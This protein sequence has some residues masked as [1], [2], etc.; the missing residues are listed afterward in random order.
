MKQSTNKKW[1]TLVELIVVITILA[2]LWT[3]AFISLQWYSS[4]ARDSKRISD[5][6]NIKKSLELFSLSTW[7]Y[8]LP[9]NW[10][11]ATF[12]WKTIWTQWTVWD[13]V[14]INLSKNL[15]KKPLDPLTELE[16]T[17]SVTI[18]KNE[19]ELLAIY[20]NIDTFS[21]N[22]I[23]NK[24][25][26]SEQIYPKIDG[27]YNWIVVKTPE[28]IIPTPSI[29][30]GEI[31][32]SNLELDDTNIN[33]QI[34]TWIYE[35]WVLDI[36]FNPVES[37]DSNSSE[38]E[39]LLVIDA[40]QD[41]YS[42]T[43]LESEPLY[44]EL[45]STN[46]A[47]EEIELAEMIILNNFAPLDINAWECWNAN[48]KDFVFSPTNLC[49]SW[50]ATWF[51]DN[52]EWFTYSWT[53]QWLSWIDTDCSAN[54]I[55]AQWTVYNSI[56][57]TKELP[58]WVVWD[59]YND[60]DTW[61]L[62]FATD[63]GWVA[64]LNW[65]NWEY[66]NQTNTDL[67]RTPIYWITKDNNWNLW[68]ATPQMYS[69]PYYWALKF[70]WNNWINYNTSNCWIINNYVR[71]VETDNDWNVWFATNWWIS[72]FDW[73]NWTNYTSTDYINTTVVKKVIKDS[74]WNLWFWT[75]ASTWW[76]SKFDWTNWT[77][78]T[79]DDWLIWNYIQSLYEDSNWNIWIGTNVWASKFDWTNFTNY[80]FYPIW[81]KWVK[82]ITQDTNWNMWFGSSL[83]L[84]KF[85]WTNNTM[86][87]TSQWLIGSDIIAS[88][89]DNYWKL[90]FS[91]YYA[92]WV[93]VS[94]WTNFID[95]LTVTWWITDDYQR[96]LVKDNN[97]DL[98]IWTYDNWAF[99]YDWTN[100]INYST[101]EWLVNNRVYWI[102]KDSKWNLWFTTGWWVSKYNWSSFTNYTTSDWLISNSC[103]DMWAIYE[104]NNW[105][106]WIGTYGWV[107]KL[108][109]ETEAFTN[110]TTTDWLSANDIRNITQ[111]SDWNMWLSAYSNW[112]NIFDPNTETVIETYNTSN[113][114][115]ENRVLKLYKD[116][117]NNIWIWAW[118]GWILKYD[119]TN[120]INQGS[121]FAWTVTISIYEDSHN[122]M[123][124]GSR[125]GYW[126]TKLDL[127][128]NTKTIYDSDDWMISENIY[129]ITEDNNWNLWFAWD[130]WLNKFW[131]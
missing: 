29:I 76:I 124:F 120:F 88:V 69:S 93:S 115:L 71:D 101:N 73:N 48:W 86:Y 51:I 131:E 27:T 14:S 75:Y 39:K 99:K 96:A 12:S 37:I 53:C 119:W 24:T 10:F 47:L 122:N 102:Y 5:I 32:E 49:S 17:Y 52:W 18:N 77:K 25:N 123:W 13:I 98:W 97:W 62:R 44:S 118:W 31:E 113:W 65:E 82:T 130:G 125:W 91:S 104:D 112:I 90:Y 111:D 107:S 117:N 45:L 34:V 105:N 6:S 108:N 66:Y 72:K 4:S 109:P 89:T 110:Y 56:N 50:T 74:D 68:A 63:W 83:R 22:N 103:S 87:S 35:T 78:Y 70:D 3:I 61:D 59:I 116:S 30:N 80:N 55:E 16:Y 8:P 126:I 114:L 84:S 127:Q 15:N 43:I 23:L 100:W 94:D 7:N 20:E 28:Y 9:D 67:V 128:S 26:A 19:Y 21:Y 57:T 1:F 2:I 81:T 60:K 95:E 33:S 46:S 92:K 54:H 38:E 42:W 58:H 64:K 85:D 41:T 11:N 121:W 79:T 40:I 129:W 106:I 36:N